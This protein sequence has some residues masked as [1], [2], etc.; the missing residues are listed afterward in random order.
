M[1]ADLL[2]IKKPNPIVTELFIGGREVFFF[3]SIIFFV[4][5]THAFF[6]YQKC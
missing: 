6:L 4:F 5:I 2:S 1:I 3:F